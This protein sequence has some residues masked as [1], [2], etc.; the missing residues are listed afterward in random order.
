MGGIVPRKELAEKA[1]RS[2]T[3]KLVKSDNRTIIMGSTEADK[4]KALNFDYFSL[5]VVHKKVFCFCERND[6]HNIVRARNVDQFFVS[7]GPQRRN[8][9][10]EAT[11]MS[12]SSFSKSR[13]SRSLKMDPVKT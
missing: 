6:F 5:S 13:L 2:E 1:A 4:L 10:L 12:C 9:R 3:R 7:F 11:K 8:L